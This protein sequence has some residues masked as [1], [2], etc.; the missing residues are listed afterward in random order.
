MQNIS[1]VIKKYSLPILFCVLGIML[2]SLSLTSEQPIEFIVA[3][4]IILVCSIFLFL[5][6][7]GSVSN[8]ITNI[9]G[10]L[11][12]LLSGFAFYTAYNSVG[13]SIKHNKDYGLV[14]LRKSHSAMYRD[15][16]FSGTRWS[17]NQDGTILWRIGIE[18][19]LRLI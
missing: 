14:G 16:T 18:R 7:S 10:G 3:S 11:S 17:I 19:A 15:N 2:I 8:K 13:V 5:T 6:V 9:I 12:L 4:I 1:V